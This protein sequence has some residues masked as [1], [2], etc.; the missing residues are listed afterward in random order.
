MHDGYRP[1]GGSQKAN[2]QKG[3]DDL[4]LGAVAIAELPKDGEVSL[5]AA[6]HRRQ[7]ERQEVVFFSAFRATSNSAGTFCLPARTHCDAKRAVVQEAPQGAYD[8]VNASGKVR[9]A[10][11]PSSTS[12][13]MSL[14]FEEITGTSSC[15]AS[16]I[17]VGVRLRSGMG[18][19]L[20]H[21]L[22]RRGSCRSSNSFR[23]PCTLAAAFASVSLDADY[24]MSHRPSAC[25]KFTAGFARKLSSPP[26]LVAEF[27][28][29]DAQ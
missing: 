16:A 10:V 13:G 27:E 5:P 2:T 17:D 9:M 23:R 7:A 18:R 19:V 3:L 8:N 14:M 20:L 4:W 11:T 15:L 25:A 6:G 21:R 29:R 26:L 1:H 22:S 24:D 28:N 12:A